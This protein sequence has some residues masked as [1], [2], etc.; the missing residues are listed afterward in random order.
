MKLSQKKLLIA[1]SA[2]LL[3]AA[4]IGMWQ[5]SSADDTL[6]LSAFQS[7]ASYCYEGIPWGSSVE[8]TEEALG[9]SLEQNPATPDYY[10]VGSVT[11]NKSSAPL[12]LEFT[13]PRL[14]SVNFRFSSDETDYGGLED[15]VLSAF[16]EEYGAYDAQEEFTTIDGQKRRST[17][18]FSDSGEP[19]SYLYVDASYNGK[20][21]HELIIMTGEMPP[22]KEE[23]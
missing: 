6:S 21:I 9:M 8:E 11:L 7:K 5:A 16:Q 17:R 10:T 18:W 12:T 1:A 15:D 14:T 20:R 22:A 2:L 4:A 3:S 13:G 23:A 19:A